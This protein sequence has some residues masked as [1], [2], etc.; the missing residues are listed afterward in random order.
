MKIKVLNE[1]AYV[2]L[3]DGEIIFIDYKSGSR[4]ASSIFHGN[5]SFF[6]VHDSGKLILL[7]R[8]TNLCLSLSATCIIFISSVDYISNY[9]TYS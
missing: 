7:E 1:I 2:L 3:E 4:S 5:V 6:D 8:L 9:R